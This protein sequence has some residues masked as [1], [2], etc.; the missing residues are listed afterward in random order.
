MP[1]G[2]KL[3]V[4]SSEPVASASLDLD[5]FFS[6]VSAVDNLDGPVRQV[7]HDLPEFLE[8]G[9]NVITFRAVDSKGNEGMGRTTITL[10][11]SESAENEE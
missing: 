2:L 5:A 1:A 4:D 8:L 7:S 3:T 9:E 10:T 11:Q 6:T